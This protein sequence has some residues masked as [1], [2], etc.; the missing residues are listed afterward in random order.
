VYKC[1]GLSA[2]SCRKSDAAYIRVGV[3]G[4]YRPVSQGV[5][6]RTPW[7][8]SG[9]APL[10]ITAVYHI[11]W[12]YYMGTPP[13]GTYL[14]KT[15]RTSGSTIGQVTQSC[16]T[17]GQLVCQDISSVWSEPGDSGSPMMYWIEGSDVQLYGIL[18]GGPNG[19]WN[20]TYSSPLAGIEADLGPL[21]NLCVPGYGC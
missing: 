13:V 21:T 11:T 10:T 6:A 3:G 19:D 4:S 7:S 2:P 14:D 18:W 20:T 12:R 15:G 5:V 1:N 9:P 17:I 8:F 16:V